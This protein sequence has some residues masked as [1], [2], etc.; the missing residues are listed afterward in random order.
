[1]N[2]SE[3]HEAQIAR[4]LRSVAAKLDG[5][6]P[7]EDRDRCVES[8]ER[9]IDLDLAA[10]DKIKLADSDVEMVLDKLGAPSKQAQQLALSIQSGALKRAKQGPDRVWLGVCSNLA[11]RLGIETWMVRAA[12]IASALTLLLLPL[13]I[14]AYIGLYL[15]MRWSAGKGVTEEIDAMRVGGRAGLTLV[16]A[17][18]VHWGSRYFLRLVYYAHETYLR[19]SVPALGEWGYLSYRQEEYFFY[20]MAFCLPLA[21]LSAL[22]LANGWDQ[23]LKR[24]SQAGLALYGIAVSLGVASV[25]VGIIL[26]LVREFTG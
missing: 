1:M 15:E 8:L 2:L 14:I 11:A 26:D 10:L 6:L 4:Y 19:K 13:A 12:G 5:A 22:P 18:T 16:I 7:E 20:A 3:V 25:L 21:V 23:T 24:V 17:L 9:R